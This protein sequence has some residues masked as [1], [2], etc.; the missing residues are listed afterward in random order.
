MDRL[1]ESKLVDISK[2]RTTKKWREF[3]MKR[4]RCTEVRKS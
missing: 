1:S 2:Q 4:G 3:F